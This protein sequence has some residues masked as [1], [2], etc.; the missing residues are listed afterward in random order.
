MPEHKNIQDMVIYNCTF[1]MLREKEGEFLDWFRAG[2]GVLT[3]PEGSG[4]GSRIGFVPCNPRLSA[5]VSAG[6]IYSDEA[7]ARSVAFQVE[8]AD[9]AQALRWA[10]A[11]LGTLCARFA[12]KFGPEAMTFSSI[13]RCIDL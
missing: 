13:F 8:F 12:E 9:E 1:M 5:L 6:G 7:D 11:R 10:D 2:A 3:A 4:G